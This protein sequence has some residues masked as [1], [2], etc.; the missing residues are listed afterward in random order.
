MSMIKEKEK[1]SITRGKVPILNPQE[2]DEMVFY[3]VGIN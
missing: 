3:R 1:E 2:T